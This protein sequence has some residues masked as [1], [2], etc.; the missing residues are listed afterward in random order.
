MTAG[1]LLVSHGRVGQSLLEAVID[2]FGKCVLPVQYVSFYPKDDVHNLYGKIQAAAQYIYQ[3]TEGILVLVD[4]F[5]ATPY[6]IS[7][8]ALEN[9]HYRLITGMNL[10]MLINVFNYAHLDLAL[11]TEKAFNAG[12]ENIMLSLSNI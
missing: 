1:V 12:Q 2:I 9:Y 11:L 3:E 6:N 5:G 10:P 7:L 4:I 8:K